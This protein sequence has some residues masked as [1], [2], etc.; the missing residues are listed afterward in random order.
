MRVADLLWTQVFREDSADSDDA[1]FAARQFRA[2]VPA[3]RRGNILAITGLAY[4]CVQEHL[5]RPYGFIF[6]AA[7]SVALAANCCLSFL[8]Q[9]RGPD[10]AR[11]LF[12]LCNVFIQMVSF[13]IAMPAA[14]WWNGIY[15]RRYPTGHCSPLLCASMAA[16]LVVLISTLHLA[17]FPLR[18]RWLLMLSTSV[19]TLI[20]PSY[21]SLGHTKEASME[22]LAIGLGELAG[23]T[24]QRMMRHAFA[25]QRSSQNELTERLDQI[26]AEKERLT[27]E[28]LLERHR[29]EDVTAAHRPASSYGTESE[30]SALHVADADEMSG[31]SSERGPQ[32]QKGANVASESANE[33]GAPRLRT[34]RLEP[35][36]VEELRSTLRKRSSQSLA[37]LD[38]TS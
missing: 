4:A 14:I 10:Y 23:R 13:N 26:K 12:V 28:L 7:N 9:S 34:R 32:R 22:I 15:A 19:A 20:Y 21:T 30:L 35:P 27:F 18:A 5:F 1:A 24:L 25:D 38:L 36:S 17:G 33:E 8:Q 11:R 2:I 31:L 6:M 37:E 16:Y 3:A 29:A